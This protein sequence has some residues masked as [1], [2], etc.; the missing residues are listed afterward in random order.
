MNSTTSAARAGGWV[1]V[2][3]RPLWINGVEEIAPRNQANPD[4]ALLRLA[5]AYTTGSDSIAH[6]EDLL[7]IAPLGS[8]LVGFGIALMLDSTLFGWA[9]GLG[10]CVAAL[11][12]DLIVQV[13]VRRSIKAIAPFEPVSNQPLTPVEHAILAESA[14]RCRAGLSLLMHRT[15]WLDDLEQRAAVT[16]EASPNIE[17]LFSLL[18]EDGTLRPSARI[19]NEHVNIAACVENVPADDRPLLQT[20]VRRCFL[21]ARAA[22]GG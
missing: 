16:N 10:G 3:R 19:A 15:A 14:K 8:V 17:R 12:A 22:H 2:L 20:F 9:L 11:F 1:Q 6:L 13:R 4:R 21:R 7:V 5:Y 18:F